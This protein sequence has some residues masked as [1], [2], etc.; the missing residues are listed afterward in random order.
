MIARFI[1]VGKGILCLMRGYTMYISW[2]ISAREV[3]SKWDKLM[4]VFRV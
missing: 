2:E 4:R 1:R 3:H